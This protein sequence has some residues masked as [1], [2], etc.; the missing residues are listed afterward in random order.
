MDLHWKRILL[1]SALF[2]ISTEAALADPL[3][4]ARASVVLQGSIASQDMR[5]NTIPVAAFASASPGTAAANAR[6]GAIGAGSS[7]STPLDA[8]TTNSA[9]A[10][11]S[12]RIDD[13]VF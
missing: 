6:G 5:Q 3:Y 11:S 2:V 10:A 9:D 13:V 4:F 12:F 1:F 7:I 8:Q